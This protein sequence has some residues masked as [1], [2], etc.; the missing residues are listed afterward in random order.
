[1]PVHRCF[2]GSLRHQLDGNTFPTL[3]ATRRVCSGKNLLFPIRIIIIIGLLL[4]CCCCYDCYGSCLSYPH[5]QH[6]W[7]NGQR[8]LIDFIIIFTKRWCYKMKAYVALVPNWF[9]CYTTKSGNWLESR[10]LYELSMSAKGR[11]E[12][13]S[14]FY[15]K[16][17][18]N[19]IQPPLPFCLLN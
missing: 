9:S 8:L 2:N 6:R 10:V 11:V 14:I 12:T 16:E 13:K 3:H 19:W 5:H 7:A 17:M 1:M 4:C 15:V 18:W